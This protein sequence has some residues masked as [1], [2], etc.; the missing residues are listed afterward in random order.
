M[1]PGP[2]PNPNAPYSRARRGEPKARHTGPVV[3]PLSGSD[4]PA[5]DLPSGRAWSAHE[6]AMW[7]DLW[8]SPQSTQW[9]DAYVPLVALYVQI[10][11]Q[12]FAGRATAGL[13]AEAR[14]LSEHLGLSPAGMRSLGWEL[15]QVDESTGE[16][17]A[18]PGAAA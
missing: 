11:C 16:L 1:R 3:L 4:L 14:Y 9:D 15:E 8:S 12:S 5:P 18:L 2:R 7:A 13:A 17:Y 6:Q 10:T